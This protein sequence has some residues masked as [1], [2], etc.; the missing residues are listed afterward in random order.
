MLHI[1]APAIV[2]EERHDPVG[3]TG[4]I[5]RRH[6]LPGSG[7]DVGEGRNSRNHGSASRSH[8]LGYDNPEWEKYL[9]EAE[10]TLDPEARALKMEP[11][12]KILQD[13]AIMV[14]ALW[15]PV[16]FIKSMKVHGMNGH[17]TTYHQFN[18]VWIE[19]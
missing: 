17:P 10:A 12:E 7:S 13:D 6:Q 14:Q 9:D 11:V 4:Y 15:R 3:Q 16:Y 19:H 2:L 8:G 18:K 5:P 1:R